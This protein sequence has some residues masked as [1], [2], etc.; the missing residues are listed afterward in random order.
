VFLAIL[1]ELDPRWIPYIAAGAFLLAA[2][3]A[4]YFYLLIRRQRWRR[5][6]DDG[7]RYPPSYPR[8]AL[9]VHF[10]AL[11]ATRTRE[12]ATLVI[13]TL[14][15]GAGMALTTYILVTRTRLSE[16]IIVGSMTLLVAAFFLFS[17]RSLEL[18]GRRLEAHH[19][20]LLA[21]S[22]FMHTLPQLPD[23]EAAKARAQLLEKIAAATPVPET[24]TSRAGGL[25]RK[26][27]KT[28]IDMIRAA[29]GLKPDS[30]TPPSPP[31][32]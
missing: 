16:A 4:T 6:E 3:L 1:R 30:A 5:H 17:Y 31:P 32:A 21:M 27:L 9:E 29:A 19:V 18:H 13:G 7:Y 10:A 28:A 15:A 22:D 23:A 26:E 20:H 24:T 14:F 8:A 11:T 2:L 25:R 12:I